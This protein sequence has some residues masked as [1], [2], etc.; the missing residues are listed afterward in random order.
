MRKEQGKKK[1]LYYLFIISVLLILCNIKIL[2][3]SPRVTEA[4][5][6]GIENITHRMVEFNNRKFDVYIN[7]NVKFISV[8]GTVDSWRD[9]KKVED[10][11]KV[12]APS[13]YRIYWDIEYGCEKE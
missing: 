11:F 8:H 4:S 2:E 6:K 12:M 13:D 1:N 5:I 9:L 3:G 7:H 10:H